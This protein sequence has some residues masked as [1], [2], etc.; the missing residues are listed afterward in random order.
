MRQPIPLLAPKPIHEFHPEEYREYLKSIARENR[1]ESQSKFVDGISLSNKSKLILKV[2][3]DRAPFT[4]DEIERLCHEKQV[5]KL[6]LEEAFYKRKI[7]YISAEGELV[8]WKPKTRKKKEKPQNGTI[9]TRKRRK[10]GNASSDEGGEADNCED[11]FQL[12]PDS[13]VLH[14]KGSVQAPNEDTSTGAI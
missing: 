6:K 2:E 8:E 1:S 7:P 9:K 11:Q 5:D 4:Q 13:P 14:E 10:K 12:S 3:K